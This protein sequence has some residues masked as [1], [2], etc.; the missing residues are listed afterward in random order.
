[1]IAY[2]QAADRGSTCKPGA[3]AHHATEL[4]VRWKPANIQ[5]DGGCFMTQ[6]LRVVILKPSKYMP[7]GYVERFRWGFMPNSTVPYLRSMTPA[8][9]GNMPTLVSFAPVGR[10]TISPTR[11]GQFADLV[12]RICLVLAASTCREFFFCL[13]P[14]ALVVTCRTSSSLPFLVGQCGDR[15]ARDGWGTAGGR[16]CC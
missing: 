15:V 7:D 4:I 8:V 5:K 12:S 13:E 9:V 11:C 10:R 16:T 2:G 3:A 14:V 6:P 1:M